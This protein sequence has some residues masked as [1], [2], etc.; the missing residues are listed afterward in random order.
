M[1]IVVAGIFALLVAGTVVA[2]DTDFVPFSQIKGE[3]WDF[4]FDFKTPRRVV[5]VDKEGVE[6]AQW[7]LVYTVTNPDKVAHDFQPSATMFTDTGR[8]AHDSLFPSVVE[9]LKADFRLDALADATQMMG[10]LKAGQDEARD[11]VFV[12]PEVDPRMD[13]FTIFVTGLSGEFIIKTIPAAKEGDAPKSVVLRKTMQLDFKF[14]GDEVDLNADK[15][16]LVGQKWI[17]R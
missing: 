10:A 11:A 15:V 3:H 4:Q 5:T 16:H 6:H 13:G 2:I 17:W 12:F 7:A 14:P 9:K 1:R 8:I